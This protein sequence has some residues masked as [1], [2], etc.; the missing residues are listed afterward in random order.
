MN[1][2]S[3]GDTVMGLQGRRA[4]PLQVDVLSLLIANWG[5]KNLKRTFC[6]FGPGRKRPGWGRALCFIGTQV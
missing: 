4:L 6:P 3:L 5:R 2:G 1:E